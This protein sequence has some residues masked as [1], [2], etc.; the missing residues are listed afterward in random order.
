MTKSDKGKINVLVSPLDHTHLYGM[1]SA[2]D[3]TQKD[4]TGVGLSFYI[5]CYLR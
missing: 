2:T 5:M 4:V 1:K 3:K